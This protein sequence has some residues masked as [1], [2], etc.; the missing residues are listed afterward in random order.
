MILTKALAPHLNDAMDSIDA[1]KVKPDDLLPSSSTYESSTDD[2]QDKNL[3]TTANTL[4][5]SVSYKIASEEPTHINLFIWLRIMLQQFHADQIH[6]N[7]AVRLMFETASVGALTGTTTGM[8]ADSSGGYG[9]PK[10]N[11]NA[12][13][14]NTGAN[15]VEY[16]QF[17]SIC[18][19]LFPWMSVTE[20]AFLYAKCH[21]SGKR[22]VT[23]EI[24][25]YHADISGY[26]AHSLKLPP[27]SEAIPNTAKQ[28]SILTS[29][30]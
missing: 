28:S 20:I 2:R 5:N 16:P 22:R 14:N 12:A 21:Y 4:V 24:F 7:A 13:G 8:L 27:Y 25:N 6:R 30:K 18:S 9:S 1:L 10:G 15:H 19:T 29:N 3:H 26:F 11:N 23:A 17:Q